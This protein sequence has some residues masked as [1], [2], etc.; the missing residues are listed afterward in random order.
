MSFEY[1][2]FWF[3]YFGLNQNQSGQWYKDTR[4]EVA[5]NNSKF[6]ASNQAYLW[7]KTKPITYGNR[8]ILGALL[9]IGQSR[10]EETF[11]D[12]VV[13]ANDYGGGIQYQTRQ[14]SIS[15]IATFAYTFGE[16]GNPTSRQHL[17]KMW[18]NKQLVYDAAQGALASN[19][20]FAFY[21]GNESQTPDAEL[22]AERY[23]YPVAYR[24]LM[25]IVLY[26]YTTSREPSGA[27]VLEAEFT[28]EITNSQVVTNYANLGSS[29]NT[30]FLRHCAYDAKRN[31][32]YQAGNGDFKL[33]KYDC[34]EKRLV[35]VY[36]IT[37]AVYKGTPFGSLTNVYILGSLRYNNIFHILCTMTS[38]NSTQLFMINA[39]TGAV[40]D[41]FGENSS[42]LTPTRTNVVQ[43]IS[44][45]AI[46]TTDRFNLSNKFVVTDVFNNV[47][48]FNF[49][50]GQMTMIDF[51]DLPEVSGST[52]FS[53]LAGDIDGLAMYTA[54]DREK[55]IK[56]L[57][58]GVL[59]PTWYTG[60]YEI[61]HM[62][63]LERDG[64]MVI[65]EDAYLT[66]DWRI[67][68][69]RRK[70]KSVVWTLNGA[71][72]PVAY[73]PR[74]FLNEWRTQS[75]TANQ[76]IAWISIGF[77]DMVTLDLIS[78]QLT[79]V[80]YK[81]SNFD[82][83]VYDAYS[84]KFI[85]R[86]N[87]GSDD[88]TIRDVPVFQITTGDIT[89]ES[90]LRDLARRAG[91]EPSNV[92]VQNIN[93]RITGAAI[94]EIS[95]INTILTDISIAYNFEI[96]KR[97]TK[98][99]FTRRGYGDI[100]DPDM[101]SIV[102]ERV[103]LSTTD[104]EYITLRSERKATQKAPGTI[105]LTYID[106]NYDYTV[107]EYKY[108]RN[109]S[110][111]DPSVTMSLALPIIMTGSQA[112]TLATRIL[113][114]QSVGRT[115]H[116][117]Q[118]PQKYINLEKGDVIELVTDAFIDYVRV[119]EIAYNGDFSISVK[120]E[121]IVTSAVVPVVVPDPVMP[122]EPPA[123]TEGDAKAII[124]DTP[125]LSASHQSPQA[126]LETYLS[127]IPATRRL[128]TTGSLTQYYETEGPFNAGSTTEIL[129]YGVTRQQLP[130][131]PVLQIDY[132][133]QFSFRLVQGD[134]TL[135]TTKTALEMLA[136]ANRILVGQQGRWEMIG[137][138]EAA[139]DPVTRL[140]TLTGICRGLRGTDYAASQHLNSDLVLLY[141]PDL[142]S[143][144]LDTDSPEKLDEPIVYIGVRSTG[145]INRDDAVA[146]INEGNSRKPWR[147]YNVHAVASGGDLDITWHRRTRLDGPLLNGT[148]YVPLDEVTE[149]YDLVLY[150]AGNIVRTVTGLTSPSFTYTAAMQATDGWSGSILSIQLDVYQISAIVGRGFPMSGVFDVE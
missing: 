42:D 50:G 132:E 28:E 138:I 150:R 30:T 119:N 2:D 6:Q 148:S 13:Y 43:A 71:D 25:Y 53:I 127:V 62:I 137:F 107:N 80:A 14:D 55:T 112:A 105:R 136:G 73:G 38:Q 60:T 8:R 98:I 69:I 10:I 57:V 143:M 74:G 142:G 130:S 88:A 36:P 118:L 104:D 31:M 81:N 139:Y 54:N 4:I 79:T 94:T 82:Y 99:T 24:G 115:V 12:Y 120:T 117:F 44:M 147:P 146:N 67:V 40:V 128:I 122:P 78:G 113:I 144:L 75:Y 9:Q 15:Y 149:A 83:P 129:T 35:D 27:P 85:Q 45:T 23:E 106:P 37:G 3:G 145:E 26:D 96:I 47:Y 49:E 29:I 72:Y 20:R 93:D 95:D 61:V 91:Y 87:L 100:F 32:M 52:A 125:L 92:V 86:V 48:L 123:L 121:A 90:L 34:T 116:E 33:Y 126:K 134:G 131:N 109:D 114:N 46:N 108:S 84:N 17:K 135:F 101:T 21:P 65:F 68:K 89:L 19:F 22:N 39:D 7:G 102:S 66:T 140:V 111:A 11:R 133:Y 97:G 58:K 76:K 51:E 103:V 56:R 41:D 59:N 5:R 1:W 77:N 124:I 63:P 64:T 70:D 16:P 110:Q 18:I 141:D